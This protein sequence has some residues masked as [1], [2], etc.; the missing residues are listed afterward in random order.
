MK[1]YG[2][3]RLENMFA[4]RSFLDAGINVTQTSDYPPGPYEPMM[5]I[6]SMVTRKDFDGRVWGPNQRISV[7]EALRICTMNGAY[8]SF[9]ENIKGSITAG[10]LA[11]FVILAN[12]PHDVDPDQIKHIEIVRTVVGGTTMYAA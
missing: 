9:E 2:K 10:K 1:E 7:D 3:K 5:A 12:D 11:D 6:Q 4:V 8:A